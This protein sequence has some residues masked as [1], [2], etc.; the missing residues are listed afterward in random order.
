[1]TIIATEIVEDEG[2]QQL[3]LFL[4]VTGLMRCTAVRSRSMIIITNFSILL[5]KRVFTNIIN[6]RC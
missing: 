5:C 4:E 2:D 1:M 3:P 6:A